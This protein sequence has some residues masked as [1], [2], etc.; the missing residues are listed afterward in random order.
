MAYFNIIGNVKHGNLTR[1]FDRP[2]SNGMA[3]LSHEDNTPQ[4]LAD[5]HCS[6]AAV[7]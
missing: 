4:S 6:S 3:A 1:Q 5:T 2:T 7:Q